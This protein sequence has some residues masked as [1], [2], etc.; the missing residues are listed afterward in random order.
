MP[1]KFWFTNPVEAL[2][3]G[4]WRRIATDRPCDYDLGWSTMEDIQGL[5]CNADMAGHEVVLLA[6]K[7]PRYFDVVHDLYVRR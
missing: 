5:A 2:P 4:K 1:E 6:T 3:D 7:R